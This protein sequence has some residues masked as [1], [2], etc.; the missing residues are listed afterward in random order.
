MDIEITTQPKHLAC[1]FYLCKYT[2]LDS[3]NISY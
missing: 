3:D 2:Q 1:H